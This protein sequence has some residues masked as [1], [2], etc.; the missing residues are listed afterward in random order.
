MNAMIK[1]N[2]RKSLL[3]SLFVISILSV[4]SIS[5]K[6]AN[7]SL[8]VCS[9]GCDCTSVQTCI[10]LLNTTGGIVNITDSGVYAEGIDIFTN[11]VTLTSNSTPYPTINV[12]SPALF[13]ITGNN[14]FVSNIRVVYNKTGAVD[15]LLSSYTS[16]IIGVGRRDHLVGIVPNRNVFNV[17]LSNMTVFS[18]TNFTI[19][20]WAGGSLAYKSI[21]SSILNIMNIEI[22]LDGIEN[23]G[24]IIKMGNVTINNATVNITGTSPVIGENYLPSIEDLGNGINLESS[25]NIT[26]INSS[27]YSIW[28]G[29]L[30]I[31]D[32][33]NDIF[34][35]NLTYINNGAIGNVLI[36]KNDTIYGADDLSNLTALLFPRLHNITIKNGNFNNMQLDIY[37]SS[38][39]TIL[40]NTFAGNVSFLLVSYDSLNVNVSN[41]Y[42][43]NTRNYTRNALD[44]VVPYTIAFTGHDKSGNVF[45]NNSVYVMSGTLFS[46]SNVGMFCSNNLYNLSVYSPFGLF[47]NSGASNSTYINQSYIAKNDFLTTEAYNNLMYDNIL[48]PFNVTFEVLAGYNITYQNM[49]NRIESPSFIVSN[50]A[51]YIPTH[52]IVFRNISTNGGTMQTTNRGS[53]AGINIGGSSNSLKY[54]YN[55]LI[56]DSNITMSIDPALWLQDNITDIFVNNSVLDSKYNSDIYLSNISKQHIMNNIYLTNVSFNKSDIDN[57]LNYNFTLANQYFYDL[58]VLNNLGDAIPFANVTITSNNGTELVLQTDVNGYMT[59]AIL[60]EFIANKTND[61]STGYFYLSNYTIDVSASGYSSNSTT[62]NIT[63]SLSQTISMTAIVSGMSERDVLVNVVVEVAAILIA[64][65]IAF[66]AMSS[67]FK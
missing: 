53:K 50:T 18:D 14:T 1:A 16:A 19:G 21:G 62:V 34:V 49:K 44:W 45:I 5:V 37:Q 67:Y 25:S 58:R 33:S 65:A 47:G 32:T 66:G 46:N 56:I 30:F 63:E 8:T 15:N 2:V 52:S 43:N 57:N 42:F 22:I 64:M 17:T 10:N 60:I 39:I 4:L 55:V 3:C 9:S 35:S 26:I 41:N 13:N 31:G 51:I 20:I 12:I 38:N 7:S 61:R 11:N 23:T 6:A 27:I 59:R 36:G 54:V 40:N 48:T 28:G 24:I 29:S